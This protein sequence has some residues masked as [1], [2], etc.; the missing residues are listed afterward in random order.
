MFIFSNKFFLA[1]AAS[2]DV[3]LKSDT[4][5][6]GDKFVEIL[7]RCVDSALGM[8][9]ELNE[10]NWETGHEVPERV[11]LA[12]RDHVISWRLECAGPTAVL[13]MEGVYEAVTQAIANEP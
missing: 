12:M 2:A 5:L 6:A 8:V 11:L 3:M 1:L 9:H 4:G 10:G 7:Q 13:L